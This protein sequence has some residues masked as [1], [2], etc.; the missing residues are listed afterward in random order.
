MCVN[1]FIITA[2]APSPEYQHFCFDR[3]SSWSNMPS[4][5]LDGEMIAC[6]CDRRLVLCSLVAAV[7]VIIVG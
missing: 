6:S 1:N 2:A 7:Q 5:L 4:E 3:A